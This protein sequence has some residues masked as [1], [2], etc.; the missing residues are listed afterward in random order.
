MNFGLIYW[1]T[2]NI[3]APWL[4]R[5][6]LGGDRVNELPSVSR[7]DENTS[8]IVQSALVAHCLFDID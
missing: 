3:L 8:L 7:Y 4:A 2:N 6:R 5:R 1:R